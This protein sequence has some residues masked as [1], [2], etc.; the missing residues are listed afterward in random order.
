MAVPQ[1]TIVE[2]LFPNSLKMPSKRVAS[3]RW[4]KDI[5]QLSLPSSSRRIFNTIS[6]KSKP[7]MTTPSQKSKGAFPSKMHSRRALG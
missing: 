7:E 4:R 3:N 6:A 2:R 1:P 5:P